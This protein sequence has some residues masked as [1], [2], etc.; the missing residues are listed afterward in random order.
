MSVRGGVCRA[1]Q[2]T[3]P[4]QAMTWSHL[5]SCSPFISGRERKSAHIRGIGGS[6]EQSSVGNRVFTG[7]FELSSVWHGFDRAV[8]NAAPLWKA[9]G[10]LSRANF[11]LWKAMISSQE[12]P[13][14]LRGD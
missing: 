4:S 6:D 11:R 2:S 14:G 3:C 1:S 5:A 9:V 8:G 12:R 7:L 10:R 13:F